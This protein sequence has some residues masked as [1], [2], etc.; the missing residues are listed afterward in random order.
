MAPAAVRQA[1]AEQPDVLFFDVRMPGMSG[2]DAATELADQWP[3]AGARPFPLLVFITAFDEYAVR[4]PRS[5]GGGLPAQTGAAPAPAKTVEKLQK[6]LA[7]PAPG[8]AR[9]SPGCHPAGN[10]VACWVRPSNLRSPSLQVIQ[11]SVG[12]TLHSAHCRRL[13][14]GAADKYVRVLTAQRSTLIHYPAAPSCKPSSM[15]RVLADPPQH[16]PGTGQRHRQRYPRRRP[17]SSTFRCAGLSEP[18]WLLHLCAFIQNH[19]NGLGC[20]IQLA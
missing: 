11:T 18:L 16:R 8:S 12:T 6:L 4:A 1:L 19:V 13:V 17:A 15:R 7:Q 14:P 10:C 9:R 3:C 5:P 2:L 20:F